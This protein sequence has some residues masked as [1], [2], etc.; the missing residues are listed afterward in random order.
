MQEAISAKNRKIVLWKTLHNALVASFL[1]ESYHI[2]G[3]EHQST[4]YE[5]ATEEQ[6][7]QA[8]DGPRRSPRTL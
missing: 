5:V 6:Q 4:A 8:V 3:D 7:A 1:Q 2:P